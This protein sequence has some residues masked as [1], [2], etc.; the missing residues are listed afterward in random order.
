MP[1]SL[2]FRN[3]LYDM[4]AGLHW[5][6]L[7][8]GP[9][10]DCIEVVEAYEGFPTP[11]EIWRRQRPMGH[12]EFGFLVVDDEFDLDEVYP[13]GVVWGLGSHIGARVAAG[14]FMVGWDARQRASRRSASL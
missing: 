13:G 6:D 3:S 4:N 11:I 14:A 7:R 10:D 2:E 8:G 9:T 1:Q 5:P 12:W